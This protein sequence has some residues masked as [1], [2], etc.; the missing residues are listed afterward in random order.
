MKKPVGVRVSV[1]FLLIVGFIMGIAG[2][3]A[4]QIGLT[5][6]AICLWTEN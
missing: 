2:G 1:A 5:A 4:W 6:I 3:S